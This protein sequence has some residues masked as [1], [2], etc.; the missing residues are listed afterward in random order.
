MRKAVWF[1]AILFIIV[2]AVSFACFLS[3]PIYE[4]VSGAFRAAG[5]GIWATITNAWAS[6]G[7]FMGSTGHYFLAWTVGV[8]AV[9]YISAATLHAFWN[10]HAPKQLG[11][12]KSSTGSQL[13]YTPQ[14]AP[15]VPESAP[16][17]Q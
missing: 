4:A 10:R 16:A 8:M 14:T 7:L 12:Q 2:C 13:P 15:A 1:F 11:G 3:P 9:T 6:L 5:G 17:Q